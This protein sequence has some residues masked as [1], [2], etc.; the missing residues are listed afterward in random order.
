MLTSSVYVAEIREPPDVAEADGAAERRQHELGGVRPLPAL[1]LLRR[2][3]LL[4]ASVALLQV[5]GL[6]H[7]NNSFLGSSGKI[8]EL[9]EKAQTPENISRQVSSDSTKLG[10]KFSPLQALLYFHEVAHQRSARVLSSR[11]TNRTFTLFSLGIID[12]VK[13]LITPDLPTHAK[14]GLSQNTR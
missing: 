12:E 10:S 11:K 8:H 1:G 5:R 4:V 7:I 2:A 14:H 6:T 9:V 3:R 13:S